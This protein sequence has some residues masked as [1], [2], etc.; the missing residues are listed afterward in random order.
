MN[1]IA[2]LESEQMAV[3]A[4]QRSIPDFAPT[5]DRWFDTLRISDK[6]SMN[7]MPDAVAFLLRAI[8]FR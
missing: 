6:S 5:L 2:E 8:R 4:A 1:I 7:R 3:V